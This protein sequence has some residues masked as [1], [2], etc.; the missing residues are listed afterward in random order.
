[1]NIYIYR[2]IT[3]Y[4]INLYNVLYQLHLNNA[5]KNYKAYNKKKRENT[6]WRDRVSIK[7]RLDRDIGISNPDFKTAVI[8]IIRTLTDIVDSMPEQMGKVN[9]DREKLESTKNK[10]YWW[11]NFNG[12]EECFWSML[13]GRP[14]TVSLS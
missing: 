4:T 1:M 3:L 7:T 10:C 2:I 5:G 14:K 6:I 13:I 12:N 8:N 11:K 9:R